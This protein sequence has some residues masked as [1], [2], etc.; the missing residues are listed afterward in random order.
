MRLSI[1]NFLYNYIYYDDTKNLLDVNR[2]GE[3]IDS[4]F[5][6]GD[7]QKIIFIVRYPLKVK[8][9]FINVPNLKLNRF[10]WFL[11]IMDKKLVIIL[12]AVATAAFIFLVLLSIFLIQAIIQKPAQI[13][14]NDNVVEVSQNE[15]EQ[16]DA[17]NDASAE[18]D[19]V[20][21]ENNDFADSTNQNRPVADLSSNHLLT[22]VPPEKRYALLIGINKYNE[23]NIPTLMSCV[24]DM[25]DLKDVL[26]RYAKFLPKNITLMT[27]DSTGKLLPTADN[28]RKKIV[29][30]KSAVPQDALLIVAFSCHGTRIDMQNGTPIKS[31]L[32]TQD[33]SFLNLDSYIDREWL[34]K[35]IDECPA[36]KKLLFCDACRS[37]ATKAQLTAL[38]NLTINGKAIRVVG[39]DEPS[40]NSWKYKYIYISACSEGQVA[41]DSGVN[42]LFT[43]FL[44]EGIRTGEAA[45]RDGDLTAF[46]WF[47]YASKKTILVSQQRFAES[48]KIGILGQT[49][50][51][52]R[53]NIPAEASSFI[54]TKLERPKFNIVLP[55]DPSQI[56][57]E[58]YEISDLGSLEVN[59]DNNPNESIKL[60][61]LQLPPI[62]ESI[63]KQM[64][65]IRGIFKAIQD[66]KDGTHP[67][68]DKPKLT[69]AKARLQYN[70]LK[71]KRDDMWQTLDS[72]TKTALE[73][74]IASNPDA[75]VISF[76][77]LRPADIEIGE[78]FRLVSFGK[79]AEQAKIELENVD[80]E[81]ETA[82]A[83]KTN[84][85]HKKAEE[86][87]ETIQEPVNAFR[88]K[89][90]LLLLE[91][92]EGYNNVSKNEFSDNDIDYLSR[93]IPVLLNY[94]MDWDEES[95]WDAADN[96][97][98]EKRPCV[99]LEKQEKERLAEIKKLQFE[100]AMKPLT[101]SGYSAGER[102]T[103][104]VNGAEFA[105][106]WCPAGSFKM[107]NLKYDSSCHNVT[108]SKGFWMMET[109]VTQKQ[110]TAI[111]EEKPSDYK[112]DDFPVDRISWYSCQD[113][114]KKCSKLG[115]KVELP[116]EAQW[117]YACRAGR[118]DA[119]VSNLKETA[120]YNEKN[121]HPVKTKKP[122]SWGL[123]DMLGNVSEWCQ[124]WYGDYPAE[125][126][127][128]ETGRP[129][130]FF[131]DAALADKYGLA[132][133][134]SHKRLKDEYD[135]TG[136]SDGFQRV[137]RG[138]SYYYSEH[139]CNPGDRSSNY[140]SDNYHGFRCVIAP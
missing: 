81:I 88:E 6:G 5:L 101:V 99:I 34:F 9:T 17:S 43:A 113:F 12:T 106:R 98:K 31:Y 84:S 69:L 136:P 122:N 85:M 135:P 94:S 54:I 1:F 61:D 7:I 53:I 16:N 25:T 83:N 14:Q 82:I 89:V 52:P 47:D 23:P 67:V 132:P 123:Y 126:Y 140:P 102:K 57:V 128:P 73:N 48:P 78:F 66:L 24:R 33:T 80:K 71:S 139:S 63:V 124:D 32:C 97:W 87:F 95:L 13:N 70:S 18:N 64:A 130:F 109:E 27:D 116:T 42:S 108:L 125:Y 74:Q 50:Q 77:S 104:V 137:A 90:L 58:T 119:V 79:K 105:F 56:Q 76:K 44:L 15:L 86:L 28:I 103:I 118:G 114:C 10:N 36:E 19:S 131:V 117:E 39:I 59:A 4:F 26:V 46:S 112:G 120:W 41:I 110:W 51:T 92:C 40:S 75:S 115:F 60:E 133:P 21:L 127:N 91:K 2:G 96:I 45:L 35:T 30:L 62:P 107:G 20:F 93:V 8:K 138:G 22:L 11:K 38:S 55:D 29:E 129:V 100:K 121:A 37:L 72:S 134:G 3:K 49:E 111:M 65:M 68:L